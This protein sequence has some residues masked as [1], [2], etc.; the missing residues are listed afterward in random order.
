MTFHFIFIDVSCHLEPLCEKTQNIQLWMLFRWGKEGKMPAKIILQ[1]PFGLFHFTDNPSAVICPPCSPE[2]LTHT[3]SLV[4]AGT[5]V[6]QICPHCSCGVPKLGNLL[7]TGPAL[8]WEGCG[9][10][11]AR[12]LAAYVTF[13]KWNSGTNWAALEV[14]TNSI[15]TM[16]N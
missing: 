14:E 8:C 5:S 1:L 9:R 10:T 7:V 13:N 12:N 2:I 6:C 15:R 16:W 3:F 4:P 11:T